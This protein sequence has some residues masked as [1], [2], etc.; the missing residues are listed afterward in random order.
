M[1]VPTHRR[2]ANVDRWGPVSQLLHWAI[3][4]LIVVLGYLGLTMTDL[5]NGANKI[6]KRGRRLWPERGPR[7]SGD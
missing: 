5:P 1:S 2:F 3:V 4:V 6:E 7:L